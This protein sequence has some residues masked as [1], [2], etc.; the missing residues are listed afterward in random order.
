MNVNR[1]L[2]RAIGLAIGGLIAVGVGRE[3]LFVVEPGHRGIVFDRFTGVRETVY[4]EGLH[5][6]IPFLQWPIIYDVRISP[7]LHRTETASKDLQTIRLSVRVL[8]QPVIEKL[9]WI[10]SQVGLDYAERVLPSI[11]NEVLKAVVAEFDADELVT[12]REAVSCDIRDRLIKRAA[13]YQIVLRDVSIINLDFSPEYTQAIERKQVEQQIAERQKFLVEKA[14]QEQL[15]AVIRVEGETEAGRLLSEA[16]KISP[17]FLELR[18]IEAAKQI[19]GYLA[20]S[21][22]VVY[23]PNNGGNLLLNV[24][25]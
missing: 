5:F 9:P 15:A 19:A 13:Y 25:R 23:L 1:F 24:P 14:K 18:K 20:S 17:E 22:H 4:D 21:N 6:V 3:Y 7:S 10:F 16:M 11:G 2:N 8:H 12:Q